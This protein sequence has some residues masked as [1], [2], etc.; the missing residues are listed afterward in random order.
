MEP[1]AGESWRWLVQVEAAGR[2]RNFEGLDVERLL[3]RDRVHLTG[4]IVP[5]AF[6]IIFSLSGSVGPIIGQN[7]GARA[8]GRVRRTL[9]DGLIFATFYTLVTSLVLFLLRHEIA[10]L[11]SAGGRTIDL[12]LFFCTF[13]AGSWAFAGAQFVASAAFNN[14]GH[15]NI[16]IDRLG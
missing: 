2:T 15:P 4:R 13:I 5:V 9:T 12:V 7:F 10:A 8:Y 11:F 14:L 1:R 6:G 16:S 3:F